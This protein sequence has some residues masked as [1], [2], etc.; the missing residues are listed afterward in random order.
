M[1]G[2][3]RIRL[4]GG[5]TILGGVGL[6]LAVR[7]SRHGADDQVA[8]PNIETVSRRRRAHLWC[9]DGQRPHQDRLGFSVHPGQL[10]RENAQPTLERQ[11]T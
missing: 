3:R 6:A 2:R 9:E 4:I 7:G 5:T 11:R 8:R 10:T 1:A